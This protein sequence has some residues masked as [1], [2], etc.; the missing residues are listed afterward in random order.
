MIETKGACRFCGQ[1]T[2]VKV[3]D[4]ATKEE[5]DEKATLDCNCREACAYQNRLKFVEKAEDAI[6]TLIENEDINK[7]IKELAK[8]IAE[9]KMATVTIT[10][11]ERKYA[12]S[13]G[14]EGPKVSSTLTHKETI[15]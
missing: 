12:L 5:I 14:K 9:H 3:P 8:Y 4:D 11:G 15:E 13:R 6:D 10:Q 2:I 7:I 1:I